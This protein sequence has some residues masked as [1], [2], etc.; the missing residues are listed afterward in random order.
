MSERT[1]ENKTAEAKMAY[2]LVLVV[3]MI[4]LPI[5]LS[6]LRNH[7]SVVSFLIQAT[8]FVLIASAIAGLLY[9]AKIDKS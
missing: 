3:A 2:I 1:Q 8:P 6:F 5:A 7:V 4:A 9:S